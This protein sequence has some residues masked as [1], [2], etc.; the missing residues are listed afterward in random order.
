MRS[1]VTLDKAT[2]TKANKLC[3]GVKYNI[4]KLQ[5]DSLSY[6]CRTQFLSFLRVCADATGLFAKNNCKTINAED[7]K[8][9]EIIVT[10]SKAIYG[11]F[12]SNVEK[13]KMLLHPDVLVE[14]K[15]FLFYKILIQKI[16]YCYIKK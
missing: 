14:E 1:E 5:K 6:S 3:Y 15:S 7:V 13:H 2:I 8:Y 16:Y 11:L 12:F 4:N 10:L 9:S